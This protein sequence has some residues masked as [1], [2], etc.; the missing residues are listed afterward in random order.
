VLIAAIAAPGLNLVVPC[1]LLFM[2]ILL[3]APFSAARS[4]LI[5]DI[6]PDGRYTTAN[7]ISGIT[8]QAATRSAS[9]PAACWAPRS[10]RGRRC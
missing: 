2:V 4:A 1:G 5:R 8:R 7:A 10:T 6:F 9:P 3:S